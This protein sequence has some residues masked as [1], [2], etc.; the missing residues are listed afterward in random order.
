MT[1][2]IRVEVVD[3]EVQRSQASCVSVE[4]EETSNR[5]LRQELWSCR[6]MCGEAETYFREHL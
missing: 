5:V 6:R 4:L 2:N 1:C 3:R